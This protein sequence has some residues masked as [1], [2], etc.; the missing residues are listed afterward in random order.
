MNRIN[1]NHLNTNSVT[2]SQLELETLIWAKSLIKHENPLLR[3]VARFL[4][5][6]CELNDSQVQDTMPLLGLEDVPEPAFQEAELWVKFFKNHSSDLLIEAG[7]HLEE[8]I[9]QQRLLVSTL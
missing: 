7:Q 4:K 9:D 6:V 1:E 3:D 8:W 5:E 2:N